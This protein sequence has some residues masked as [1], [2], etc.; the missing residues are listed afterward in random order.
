[1]YNKYKIYFSNPSM[2]LIRNTPSI[3]THHGGRQSL[4]IHQNYKI[5][6]L[7]TFPRLRSSPHTQGMLDFTGSSNHNHGFSRT[8][9]E[10]SVTVNIIGG[11][12]GSPRIRGEYNATSRS[13][14]Y[15]PGS[16]PLARGIRS[17][18]IPAFH[19]TGITPACAGNTP[20]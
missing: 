9:G 8:R 3:F 6:R 2:F 5:L 4:L 11:R 14:S 18:H 1:M 15:P 10:Y 13:P 16:P 12:L 17:G 19:E 7:P 20:E